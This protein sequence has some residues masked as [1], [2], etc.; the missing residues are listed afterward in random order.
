[1]AETTGT[2]HDGST[3]SEF[4][5]FNGFPQALANRMRKG[6]DRGVINGDE[7]DVAILRP[8]DWI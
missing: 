1:M 2:L 5:L 8:S 3:A 4:C 7:G 6:I